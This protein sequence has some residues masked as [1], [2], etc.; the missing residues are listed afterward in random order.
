MGYLLVPLVGLLVVLLVSSGAFWVSLGRPVHVW[1]GE[2]VDLR[3]LREKE[4][5]PQVHMEATR[6]IMDHVEA[7]A[8][9]HKALVLSGEIPMPPTSPAQ[10]RKQPKPG[11][12]ST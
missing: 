9:Q 3:D 11:H 2:P 6:R 5:S 4:D 1:F 12:L 7:L 10:T 8:Q